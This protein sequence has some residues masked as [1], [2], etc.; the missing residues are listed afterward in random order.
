MRARPAA[1][2]R[3]QLAAYV[4][5]RNL[6]RRSTMHESG[7]L[8]LNLGQ[9]CPNCVKVSTSGQCCPNFVKFG[10]GQFGPRN[11]GTCIFVGVLAT[12]KFGH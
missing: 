10:H 8:C 11:S 2:S 9:W 5:S 7:H 12:N 6:G 3:R 4:T 1:R